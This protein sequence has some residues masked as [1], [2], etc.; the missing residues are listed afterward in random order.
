M[1][2]ETRPA[3]RRGLTWRKPAAPSIHLEVPLSLAHCKGSPR[4]RAALRAHAPAHMRRGVGGPEVAHL[5]PKDDQPVP[6]SPIVLSEVRALSAD[7]TNRT[8]HRA[9]VDPDAPALRC[10]ETPRPGQVVGLSDV[11]E[12]SL[13][14]P[15]RS[16]SGQLRTNAASQLFSHTRLD[17]Q[18]FL[19]RNS[20]RGIVQPFADPT[21]KAHASPTPRLALPV[22]PQPLETPISA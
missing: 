6:H 20:A 14:S 2:A 21:L 1:T 13:S 18:P 7:V 12:I 5:L 9:A 3:R 16:V 4:R 10:I 17:A 8:P 11:D 19:R 22:T 15:A